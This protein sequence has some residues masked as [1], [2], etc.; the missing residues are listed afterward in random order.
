MQISLNGEMMELSNDSSLLS[1]L[2]NRCFAQRLGMAVAVNDTVVPKSKWSD[3]KLN[4]KDR[5]LVIAATK[6]G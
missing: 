6:G 3:T 5:I 4:D 2:E 1:L